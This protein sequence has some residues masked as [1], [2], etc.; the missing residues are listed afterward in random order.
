M[1]C[2]GQGE[3]HG[4]TPASPWQPPALGSWPRVAEPPGFSAVNHTDTPEHGH[5]EMNPVPWAPGQPRRSTTEPHG[6]RLLLA[7]LW[8]GLPWGTPEGPG[9]R[10]WK[11]VV[12]QLLGGL[13]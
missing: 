8:S 7:L 12:P 2:T 6:A 13:P 9:K 5:P 11:V 3:G 1:T 10:R 4:R